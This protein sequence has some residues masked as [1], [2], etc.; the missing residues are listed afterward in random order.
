MESGI[1]KTIFFILWVY[2]PNNVQLMH[3][4]FATEQECY[5]MLLAVAISYGFSGE[6]FKGASCEESYSL[7]TIE[8][9]KETSLAE[10]RR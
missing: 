6:P 7:N 1:V 3:D 10:P 2:L 9:S 4:T 8:E 5:D